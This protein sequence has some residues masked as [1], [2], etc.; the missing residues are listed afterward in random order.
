MDV[1]EKNDLDPEV[2]YEEHI[3]NHCALDSAIS[4]TESRA[5]FHDC[6]DRDNRIIH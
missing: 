4:A 3:I 6:D 5:S 1:G 2:A